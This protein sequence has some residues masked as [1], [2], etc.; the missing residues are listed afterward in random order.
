M[1]Q[2]TQNS[3]AKTLEARLLEQVRQELGLS[4][5]LAEVVAKAMGNDGTLFLLDVS[6]DE[7]T[8]L[9]DLCYEAGAR[10]ECYRRDEYGRPYR[11]PAE[12]TSKTI[13]RYVFGDGSAIVVEGD[14]WDVE[15]AD[16]CSWQGA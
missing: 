7:G 2:A 13:F 1:T 4:A 15:G 14:A 11:V 12:A 10:L 6:E 8:S 3:A 16:L 5:P 9:D